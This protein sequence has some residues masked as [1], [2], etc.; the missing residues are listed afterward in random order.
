M[1]ESKSL[2]ECNGIPYRSDDLKWYVLQLPSR[3]VDRELG[4][5]TRF[6]NRPLQQGKKQV[7]H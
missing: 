2:L 4:Y 6:T 3:L 5:L 7:L 1:Q